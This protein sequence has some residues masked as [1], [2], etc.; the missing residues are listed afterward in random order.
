MLRRPQFKERSPMVTKKKTRTK[1]ARPAKKKKASNTSKNKLLNG[2]S[3]LRAAKKPAKAAPAAS[4]SGGVAVGDKAPAFELVDHAGKA[5]SSKSLAGKA[6]VL[7]FYPKDDTP[8]CTTEACGFRD[9]LP[10][11]G[12]SKVSVI[13]VSPDSPASH[14]KFREKYTLPFTL[15]SDPEKAL[16]NAY[17]V[18]VKKINYG[19]E[20][21]GVER[22]TFLVDAK[23]R[24]QKVWRRVKVAGHVEQVLEAAKAL[25]S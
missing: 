4:L 23:G 24:V 8:G 13:G 18:W 25:A 19:R 22:S 16:I 14:A 6:Y 11:F 2:A 10:K 15:A 9:D 7:Y 17:G 12:R 1:P 3:K 21:M 20:Y 5:I